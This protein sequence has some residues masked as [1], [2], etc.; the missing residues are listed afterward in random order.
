VLKMYASLL[1]K[2]VLPSEM[3]SERL[4]HNGKSTPVLDAVVTCDEAQKR[5]VVAVANKHPEKSVSLDVQA[6]TG[7]KIKQLKAT[8]LSGSSPDDYNDLG[9]ENRVVPETKTLKVEHGTVALSAHSV[10][11]FEISDASDN[12]R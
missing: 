9:A 5:F 10:C 2:N 6:L 7:K 11:I 4:E 1:E 3:V 12:S 8:I